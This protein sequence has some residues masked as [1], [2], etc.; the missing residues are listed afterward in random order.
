MHCKPRIPNRTFFRPSLHKPG[1]SVMNRGLNVGMIIGLIA[2]LL[3][4]TAYGAQP[5]SYGAV[6]EVNAAKSWI[7]I[8]SR[9][10][11]VTA[12]TEIRNLD[13]RQHYLSAIAAGQ[14]VLYTATPQHEL[15]QLWVYPLDGEKRARLLG[16]EVVE[17][18]P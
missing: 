8:D 6:Q 5:Q 14:P 7:T 10:L 17:R 12:K 18:F 2:A 16:R 1:L 4:G 13:T 11:L 15:L 3:T 9:R